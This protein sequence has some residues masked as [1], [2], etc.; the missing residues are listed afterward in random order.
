MKPWRL[1]ATGMARTLCSSSGALALLTGLLLAGCLAAPVEDAPDLCDGDGPQMWG[2]LETRVAGNPGLPTDPRQPWSTVMVLEGDA[3]Y[4]LAVEEGNANITWL[5]A[6]AQRMAI[7][8]QQP[9]AADLDVTV[10]AHG[11]D[12]RRY[13]TPSFNLQ[14]PREGALAEAGKGALV[15]TAGFWENGTLFYTNMRELDEATGQRDDSA[16]PRAGWYQ[17]GGDRPLQVYVYDQE[18][19]EMPPHWGS[20]SAIP[21][22]G[23]QVP[24]SYGTTIPGFNEALKGLSTSNV[25]AV[26][27]PAGQA[28]TR[29]GNEA[30]PLYGDDLV[31]L[32]RLIAVA[33]QPCPASAFEDSPYSTACFRQ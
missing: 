12:C 5:A 21:L 16:W 24:G 3:G 25:V 23:D 1:A 15:Y 29:P 11:V 13:S 22:D 10:T 8:T 2:A 4:G 26:R 27:V 18:R 17:P 19:S 33:D 14:A 30:H 28:Y 9:P 7:L 20:G 32:I 6:A 31:F